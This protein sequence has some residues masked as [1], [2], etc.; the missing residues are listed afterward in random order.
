MPQSEQFAGKRYA[1]EG[2]PAAHGTIEG[3][4]SSCTQP[5]STRE[6]STAATSLTQSPN[7]VPKQRKWRWDR[8]AK[9]ADDLRD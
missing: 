8:G 2:S 9:I 7:V 1:Q 5:P 3:M 4:A 6:K